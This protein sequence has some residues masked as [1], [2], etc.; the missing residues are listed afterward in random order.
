MRRVTLAVH[1]RSAA[2]CDGPWSLIALLTCLLGIAVYMLFSEKG[3]KCHLV[4]I[5]KCKNDPCYSLYNSKSLLLLL[6]FF[7]GLKG[8][9]QQSLS[10]QLDCTYIALF[11]TFKL[12]ISKGLSNGLSFAHSYTNVWL[13]PCKA[14]PSPLGAI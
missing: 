10:V 14:L 8:R 13:L 11:C 7:G 1:H 5:F 9:M 2:S 6:F 4:C 3:L 12:P